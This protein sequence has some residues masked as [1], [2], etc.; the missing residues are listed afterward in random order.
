MFRKE[1]ET[2]DTPFRDSGW[3]K[4]FSLFTPEILRYACKTAALRMTTI[5]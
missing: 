5:M 4:P 3:S 2:W 1:R